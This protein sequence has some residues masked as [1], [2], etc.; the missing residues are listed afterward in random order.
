MEKSDNLNIRKDPFVRELLQ[1]LPA[2]D[3]DSF[4]DRQL[5]A[6]KSAL[7]SRR[8]WSR[9]AVDLRGGF[10]FWKWRYYYVILGGRERRRLTRRD[11]L[12]MRSVT[13]FLFSIFFVSSALLGLL[14]LYMI[15][16]ALGINILEGYSF[17]IWQWFNEN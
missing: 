3:R 7:G 11:V 12:M 15:K 4:S 13:A 16:S 10:G 5:L 17:G 6:V 9:H 8:L 14:V 1:N 2:A